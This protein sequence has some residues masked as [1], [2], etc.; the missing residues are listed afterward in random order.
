VSGVLDANSKHEANCK[1]VDKT[2]PTEQQPG[3]YKD[4]FWIPRFWD[5]MN[6]SGWLSLLIRNRFDVAPKRIAMALII[7]FISISNSISWAIQ[8]IIYGRRIKNTKL[9]NDPIF[10]IGHWRSGTTLLHELLVLDHRHAFPDTYACFAPNHFLISGWYVKPLLKFLL[11]SRRPMDNMAAGWDRPQEDEFA[12]CNMGVR[13]PYLTAVFPNR[14]PQDQ[15]YLDLEGLSEK[16]SN[17]WKSKLLW[18]LKCLTVKNPKRIVLKSPPHTCRIKAL[19]ELFPNA[20]FVHIVRDPYVLFP[21]TMNLWKRLYRDEGLQTPAFA[22][23][24]EHVFNTFERMYNI[25]D[26]DKHLLGKNQFSEV[27]YEDLVADPVRQMQKIYDEL[28]LND[29]NSVR[30]N[31]ASFIDGQKDYKTNRYQLSPENREEISRRWK[32]YVLYYGYRKNTVAAE[33][34]ISNASASGPIVNTSGSM[35][36][37]IPEPAMLRRDM[38]S[39]AG[40]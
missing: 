19:L 8:S 33:Q 24:E 14:P 21:S 11:P 12:L 39:M 34:S 15:D 27:R 9:P 26:R 37:N 40:K 18:F 17:H 22:D 6:I 4:R 3:G 20:K 13:S 23:L 35:P 38:N 1:S 7:F 36:S 25:F 32:K 16:E 29:F 30:N 2:N 5:G 10:V 28:D 31:I